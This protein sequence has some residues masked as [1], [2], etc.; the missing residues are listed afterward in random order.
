[1]HEPRERQ[2][3]CDHERN[4]VGL[5]TIIVCTYAYAYLYIYIYI[6]RL[7]NAVQTVVKD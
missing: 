5:V 6:V 4:V 1:M 3:W 2:G 7:S